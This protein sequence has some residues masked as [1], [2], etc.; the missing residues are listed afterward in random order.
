M[1]AKFIMTVFSGFLR[2]AKEQEK[3]QKSKKMYFLFIPKNA[4]LAILFNENFSIINRKLKTP[5]FNFG[6]FLFF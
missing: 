1:R 5:F 4:R 3:K 6:P 2:K